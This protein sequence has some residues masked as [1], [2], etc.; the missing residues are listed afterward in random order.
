[1][2][3]MEAIMVAYFLKMF[4][5]EEKK[6]QDSSRGSS[7]VK[8]KIFIRRENLCRNSNRESK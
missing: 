5:K 8:G 7:K 3:I 1:M 2:G 4:P 6:K